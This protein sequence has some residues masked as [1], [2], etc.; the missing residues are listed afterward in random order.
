M[1]GTSIAENFA[2]VRKKISEACQKSKRDPTSVK[3]VV[4]S[5]SQGIEVMRAAVDAGVRTFGENYAQELVTKLEIFSQENLEWHFI[6]HLQTNKV[7]DVVGRVRLIHSIDSL[8]LLQKID[9]TAK[10]L[11]ITQDVLLE[12]NI[13]GE[14]SKTGSDISAVEECLDQINALTRIQVKGLMTMPPLV[15]DPE[16]NRT[17]FRALRQLRDRLKLQGE[18][19]MGTSHDYAVA[20][21]EGATII[22]VG[23]AILGER[24]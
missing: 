4:V 20:I 21:E 15:A 7:K 19:S 6:G 14:A 17:H 22:R 5:K 10:L 23:S 12:V 8:R 13:A 24:R 11:N 18:L 16:Q 1:A 2:Q 9:A 3:V